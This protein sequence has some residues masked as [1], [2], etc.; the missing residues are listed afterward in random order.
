VDET[1]D[2]YKHSRSSREI[3]EAVDPGAV[4]VGL[5]Y[6]HATSVAPGLH[7]GNEGRKTVFGGV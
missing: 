2:A 5:L 7:R 4:L 6:T 3:L 1:V